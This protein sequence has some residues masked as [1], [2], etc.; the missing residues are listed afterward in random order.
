MPVSIR[1]APFCIRSYCTCPAET[2]S[3]PHRQVFRF[4][5]GTG[6]GTPFATPAGAQADPCLKAQY[7][8][9]GHREALATVYASLTLHRRLWR[10]AEMPRGIVRAAA[11]RCRSKQQQR[12]CH[13]PVGILR[14]A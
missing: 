4:L 13:F 14:G 7:R 8:G 2:G 9:A 10:G 12:T 5:P 1:P 6:A 3:G 11:G